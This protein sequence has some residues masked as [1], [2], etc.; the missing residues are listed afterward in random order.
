MPYL[1]QISSCNSST[2]CNKQFK[3]FKKSVHKGNKKNVNMKSYN[4]SYE[5]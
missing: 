2:I 1:K 4:N 3:G 5:K